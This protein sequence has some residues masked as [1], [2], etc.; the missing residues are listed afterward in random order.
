MSLFSLQ[1]SEF[2]V[3]AAPYPKPFG[4]ATKSE[5]MRRPRHKSNDFQALFANG[6][7]LQKTARG[8]SLYCAPDVAQVSLRCA[9]TAFFEFA[10]KNS[11]FFNKPA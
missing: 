9:Q 10:D 8:M 5:G 1:K 2:L 4:C 7:E 11:T 6:S 3:I